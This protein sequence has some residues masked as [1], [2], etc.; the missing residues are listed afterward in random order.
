MYGLIVHLYYIFQHCRQLYCSDLFT[1]TKHQPASVYRQDS[2][3]D[4][5]SLLTSL[6]LKILHETLFLMVYWLS[7]HAGTWDISVCRMYLL[8]AVCTPLHQNPSI[9]LSPADYGLVGN[10]KEKIKLQWWYS[11]CLHKKAKYLVLSRE[12]SGL[13]QV[14]A[15]EL[16]RQYQQLF[17]AIC[18]IN[19]P[20]TFNTT[21]AW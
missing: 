14:K 6:I 2:F 1:E 12:R 4:I 13:G 10:S 21:L 15:E 18:P 3:D 5:D 19:C 16:I 20:H 9:Y 11:S 7:A 8:L 17:K